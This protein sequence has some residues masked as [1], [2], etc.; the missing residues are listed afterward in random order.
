MNATRR[1]V[2]RK[3]IAIVERENESLADCHYAPSLKQ[4]WPQEVAD[5]VHEVRKLTAQARK[6]FGI[7]A[8]R[9]K[10]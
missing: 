7:R 8:R 6:L 10:S 3:L 1:Q 9:K 2:I 5:E 4:V